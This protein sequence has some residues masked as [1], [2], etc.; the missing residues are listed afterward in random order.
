MLVKHCPRWSLRTKVCG[1]KVALNLFFFSQAPIKVFGIEGRYAHALYSAA[2]KS[3][4][5]DKVES[6]LDKLQV[7]AE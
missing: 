1:R 6:E 4:Q 2:A 5:L 7:I 3:K